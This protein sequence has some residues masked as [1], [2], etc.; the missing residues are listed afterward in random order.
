MP[1]ACRSPPV[2]VPSS[3]E[4]GHLLWTVLHGLAESSGNQKMG[5]MQ[6]DEVRGWDT[7]LK[8]LQ[9]G[10]PCETCREHYLSWYLSHKPVIPTD[11]TRIKVYLREWIYNLHE[12]INRRLGKPSFPL[13]DVPN[14][15]RG[16]DV[17]FALK[18]LQALMKLSVMGG[19]VSLLSWNALVKAI[20]LVK[21]I[22]GL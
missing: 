5:I 10:I 13:A 12:D 2:P 1:C 15:Y 18:Q 17:T 21:S 9:K 6:A 4:W 14:K 19:A 11:Y 16:D 22:S 7:L 3:D 8:A 20:Y